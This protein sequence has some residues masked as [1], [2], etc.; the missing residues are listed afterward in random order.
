MNQDILDFLI[1]NHVLLMISLDGDQNEH[2]KNRKF[3]DGSGSFEIVKRN[4]DHILTKY[5]EYCK[6]NV[7]IQAVF[8]K[9]NKKIADKDSFFR[10]Y[11]Y[12]KDGEMKVLRIGQYPK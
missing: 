10:Q 11:F 12:T 9:G 6:N 5:P 3:L 1:E 2:D 8:S 4:L 7:L